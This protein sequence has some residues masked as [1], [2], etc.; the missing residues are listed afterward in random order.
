MTNHPPANSA[1]KGIDIESL[2]DYRKRGLT[3][4]EIAT[5][6]GCSKQSVHERLQLVDLDGLETFRKHKDATL[7]H[8]QR[9]IVKS[10]KIG[11]AHV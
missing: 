6:T 9:K 7:E 3:L 5:L 8:K 1:P 2:I 11:R 4:Q 10:L